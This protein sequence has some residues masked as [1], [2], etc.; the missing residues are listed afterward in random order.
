[1]SQLVGREQ[2]L[3]E[4]N[5]LISQ[6]GGQFILVYGRRRVGKTTLLL[7]WAQQSGYPLI[8]WVAS[9]D[10]ASQVRLSFV[11]SLWNWVYPNSQSIPR[12]ESWADIFDLAAQ[13]IK[14]KLGEEERIILILDEF[15]YA[16]E[17]DPSLPSYLQA[18]WDH[19][20]KNSNV[21]LVLAGSHLGMMTELMSY[22]APL[23]GR[24]TGQL[25]VEPLPF[26]SLNR[27]L[28]GYSPQERVEVY[29][30]VG[31]IPAYL[32]RFNPNESVGANVQRLFIRRTGMFRSEPFMLIGDVV[33]RETQTYEAILKSIAEGNR[34]SK[35]ISNALGLPSSHLSPYLQQLDALHLIERRIPATVAPAKRRVSR[36]SRYHLVDPY[37]RFYFRFIA[38]N[39]NMVELEL[40]DLL[41]QRIDEQFSSYVGATAFEELCR[42]WTIEQARAGKL[43]FT[44]ELVGSH[45]SA[46]EQVDVV[47]INWREKAILLGECKWLQDVIGANIVKDL[48][49]KSAH[50]VSVEEWKIFYVFFSRS[51]F[52]DA[53]VAEARKID[54]RLIDLSLLIKDLDSS[55][56]AY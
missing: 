48:V 17:S 4:L 25:P 38:P 33:R 50:I 53:A 32:E 56:N 51:G 54:A 8:Y 24:F 11:K 19:R 55:A 39:L 26:S 20:F 12:F 29:S 18:A 49:A 35:A 2:D 6:P 44:P 10:T 31:G 41:W 43:P 45:W 13:L 3:A 40:S 28:P 27:F 7:H 22:Q 46:T 30:V 9:R 15:S 21:I 42:Q 36:N 37:L 23:Y 1:M 14:G 5:A 47:A 34:T 52:S 16:A